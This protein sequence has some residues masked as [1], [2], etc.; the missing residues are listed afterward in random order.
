M[1]L[2]VEMKRQYKTK[3]TATS[4]GRLTA[5]RIAQELDIQ[6]HNLANI[7]F[8]GVL[9]CR[10]SQVRFLL[11]NGLSANVTN[12]LGHNLLITSLFIEDEEKRDKMFK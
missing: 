6:K 4:S 12:E 10:F 1:S 9:T 5:R 11:N 8:K 7:L 2:A 3:E